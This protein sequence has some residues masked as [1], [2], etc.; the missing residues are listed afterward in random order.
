MSDGDGRRAWKGKETIFLVPHTH[1]DAIWVLTKEDYFYINIVIILREVADIL[2]R[3][4]EYKFMLE[5]AFLLEEVERR[6]PKLFEELRKFIREGRIEIADGEYLM[7]DTML[8]QE[9]TLV[10]EILFGKRYVKEKFGVDV[11]VMWQA[12]SFGLNAQLPQIYRKSGYKYVAF[13]RGS[14][15]R[16][17]SEFLWEGLDGTRILAHWMPLG[18]RAGLDLTKL[19]ESYEILRE[20]AAT[21]NILMPSGSG[22]MPPQPETVEVVHAW[23]EKHSSEM[24]IATPSEFFRAVERYVE[25]NGIKLDVRRG[26]MYSGKYSMV[27]PSCSSSRMWL[28]LGLRKYESMLLCCERWATLLFLLNGYY[29]S[30][31]LN[32]CWR[33]ILFTAFHDVVPGTAMDEGYKEVRRIFSYLETKLA[34]IGAA[35]HREIIREMQEQKRWQRGE[36]QKSGERSE[37]EGEKREKGTERERGE[38]RGEEREDVFVVERGKESRGRRE[39]RGKKR[40]NRIIVFNPLSWEVKNWV[41]VEL[42]FKRGEI[43]RIEGLRSGDEEIE[44]EVIKFSRYED[45]TLRYA[46]IGFVATVPP[47]GYKIYEIMEREPKARGRKKENEENFIRIVGN[48]IETRF[49]KVRIDPERALIDVFMPDEEIVCLWGNDLVLEEE[50]GDLYYHR[51]SSDTPLKTESGEGLEFGSFRVE[52]FRIQKSPLRRVVNFESR[53]YSLRW[54]YK[55][56]HKFE[57]VLWRHNFLTCIKKIVIYK[58]IPR[59]DFVTV[60]E[61]RHPRARLRVRFPTCINER[62]Y[63]CECQFGAVSRETNLFYAAKRRKAACSQEVAEAGTAGA[64]GAA[65]VTG[66]EKEGEEEWVEEPTGIFPSLRWIDYSD[67]RKGLTVINKGIP[68]NEVRDGCIYLTLLRSVFMLSSDGKTGP[69]I[70]VPEARELR[71]YTFMYALYPHRGDW[72]EAESFRHAYE[73]NYE[74]VASQMQDNEEDEGI[75][76][77]GA[78]PL[79]NTFSFLKIE[80]ASVILTALKRAEDHDGDAVVLRFYEA[81]GEATKA[82]ITLFKAPREVKEVNLLEEEEE[83]CEEAAKRRNLSVNGNEIELEVKPFEIVTLKMWF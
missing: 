54:P 28:K 47:L 9:E 59:I 35:M 32:D 5:Q 12:D 3:S 13:R 31:E 62:E 68:E 25:E 60:V 29:P 41:E 19:H 10:R 75:I 57:P 45:D 58:D 43:L 83:K 7:P 16:S 26:E 71:K 67:G 79:P 23:N 40:R 33:K 69:A 21:P 2:K 50:A 48:T 20:L 34:D 8:P 61:D 42:N 52:N 82:K 76:S 44:V 1:Y 70:P 80:P 37:E 56:T 36:E 22:G 27:F 73:F 65:G 66:E 51:Q 24:K 55:L 39:R 63:T 11:D 81:K 49:F 38:G 30:D 14:P 78:S 6:Y 17:P 4:P 53:Y 15:R 72:R 46:K 18:Y 74:L 77:S 64:A